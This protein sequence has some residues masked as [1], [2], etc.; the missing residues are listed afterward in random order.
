MTNAP[1][2]VFDPSLPAANYYIT[3]QPGAT[4]TGVMNITFNSNGT[5]GTFTSS[6]NLSIEI[7]YGS[8]TGAVVSSSELT[9]TSSSDTWG[10]SPPSGGM[11]IN[12]VNNLLD[13]TGHNQ[14]F[15][16]GSPLIASQQGQGQLVFSEASVPEPSTWIM[17]GM[18]GLI[19]PAAVRWG[20]RRR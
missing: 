8:L 15:F 3:L 10:Q 7:H 2:N 5:G 11:L 17:L 16:V 14:D 4:N 20:R 1:T 6:L 9:L 19:V 13:G 18:A 12:G